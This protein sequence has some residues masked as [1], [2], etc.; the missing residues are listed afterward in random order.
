MS[1]TARPAAVLAVLPDSDPM[2]FR[3]YGGALDLWKARDHEVVI[4]GP[5]ETGKTIAALHKLNALLCKYPRA[6]ALM[7][8][9]TYKSLLQSACVTLETKVFAYPPSHPRCPISKSGGQFPSAYTYPNGSLL[10]LGGMDKPDK[11][12]S[13]EWDFVYVNQAEELSEDDWQAL[14]GR[15]TGR[16]ANTPYPQVLADANPGPP[17]HWI[18][19]RKTLRLITSRH[20]D[21]PTLFAQNP[22]GT[23]G[24]LTE[25][26]ER[27]MAVL[28]SLTGVRLQRGRFGRWVAAEGQVYEDFQRDTHWVDRFEPEGWRRVWVVDFG[29]TNPFVWQDWLVDSDGRAFLANEIYRTGR[30]VEDHA[31]D[32]KALMGKVEPEALI[33]DHDAEDRATLE[34]HLGIRTIPAYKAL[35]PGIQAVQARLRP[36]GD[37]RP[38]LFLMRD[39]LVVRDEALAGARRPTST[40]EEFE[41]YRWPKGE[42]G[43]S[44]KEAPVKENDHGMDAMRYLV[45]YLDDV[46]SARPDTTHLTLDPDLEY[47]NRPGLTLAEMDW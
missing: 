12:L 25:R 37:G 41:V 31:R 5:Y 34:K 44:Q 42:G 21:N 6:R 32:I 27:T 4:A 47:D 20:E 10:V 36:A 15:A 14:V 40:L 3:A 35:A 45:A 29:F 38:R 30:L 11:L 13:S 23:T 2:G 43:A 9:K 18:L 22:D 46:A 8:R 19:H 26:G 33:C 1:A 16:A 7:V 28:D 24:A 39:A 17:S